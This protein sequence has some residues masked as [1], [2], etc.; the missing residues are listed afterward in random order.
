MENTYTKIVSLVLVVVVLVSFGIFGCAKEP[1]APPT[2]GVDGGQAAAPAEVFEWTCQSFI[3]PGVMCYD[4]Y[5]QAFAELAQ[6]TNGRLVITQYPADALFSTLDQTTAC[7]R[8]AI[9]MSYSF[10]GFDMN[11]FPT[12]SFFEFFGFTYDIPNFVTLMYCYGG[13]DL[14]REAVSDTSNLYYN[15]AS[16]LGLLLVSAVPIYG[17]DDLKGL[18]IH[19]EGLGVPWFNA[20]GASCVTL[21]GT[22]LYTAISTGVIDAFHFG[23]YEAPAFMEAW[24]AAPYIIEPY[25][26]IG[27][28][29]ALYINKDA[30][31]SLPDD[32]KYKLDLK[33][34]ET[35]LKT[36]G[37]NM[38][39]ES[40]YRTKL[41]TEGHYPP[42]TMCYIP[43]DEQAKM[44]QV[45]FDILQEYVVDEPTKKAME[46]ILMEYQ[47]RLNLLGAR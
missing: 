1:A 46:L 42:G 18:R 33:I 11:R 37:N 45:M 25:I 2:P 28:G 22:E 30:Y 14:L 38:R 26:G 13:E 44:D 17:M 29:D 31:N 23:G 3:F 41:A 24:D 19:T 9:E 6:E 4:N 8:G 35:A 47:D 27:V 10:P 15:T 20:M 32:L 7:E 16:I 12:F 43:K 39:M 36:T 5:E 21:A 40:R 34:M